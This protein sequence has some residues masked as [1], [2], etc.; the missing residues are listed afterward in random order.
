MTDLD[1][2]G[3]FSL[4][5]LLRLNLQFGKDIVYSFGPYSTLYSRFYTPYT[6]Y[7]TISIGLLFTL[8]YTLNFILVST[9]LS[10]KYSLLILS[11]PILSFVNLDSIYL[12]LPL[13]ILLT[14]FKQL[15]IQQSVNR[16]VLFL[17]V[18]TLGVLSLMKGTFIYLSFLTI[19]YLLFLF[20]YFNDK[21]SFILTLITY[22]ISICFFWLLAGQQI[23]NIFSF[24]YLVYLIGLNYTESMSLYFNIYN[25]I[26][27]IIIIISFLYIFFKQIDLTLKYKFF[28][29]LFITPTLFLLFKESFVRNDFPHTS[30]GYSGLMIIALI[31]PLFFKFRTMKVLFL[32][33]F[34]II[35]SLVNQFIVYN[36]YNY[37]MYNNFPLQLK[38]IYYRI[39]KPSY[40]YTKYLKIIQ[41]VREN[42]LLPSFPGTTDIYRNQQT[43]LL[44]SFNKWNPRPV[45]QSVN[46]FHPILAKMNKQH[47]LDIKRAPNIIFYRFDTIDNRFPTLDDGIS[48]P[49]IE[50]NYILIDEFKDYLIFKRNKNLRPFTLDNNLITT[51]TAVLEEK[52]DLS[53][54]NNRP[55]YLK[56]NINKT[57]ISKFI[58]FFY[59]ITP[60][61]IEIELENNKIMRYR[62]NSSICNDGFILSPLVTDNTTFKNY[63]KYQNYNKYQNNVK[64]FRLSL[65][66][67]HKDS[68]FY[69]F[70]YLFYNNKF[71]YSLY[72]IK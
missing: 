70:V 6:D 41:N 19:I 63:L 57:L 54:Y 5:E 46:V 62:L 61:S 9:S 13:T 1:S 37:C 32:F 23:K 72:Y 55:L 22:F 2:S 38:G 43:Y 15:L 53:L 47:L 59:K 8:I 44:T 52:I 48:L 71:T 20:I 66:N 49:I 31:L 3:A 69:K 24:Y 67:K 27:F 21:K 30:I 65:L 4:A 56:I 29:F 45:F 11:I 51:Q 25:D 33:I 7:M 39:T 14:N 26:I 35:F 40:F 60:L 42:Y 17:S 28:S 50:N 58:L 10:K 64:S 12:S 34:L 16:Y 36:N 18:H 68:N